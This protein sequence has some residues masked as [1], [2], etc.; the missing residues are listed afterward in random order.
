M[1]FVAI[2][3]A[4]FNTAKAEELIGDEQMASDGKVEVIYAPDLQVPYRERRS[5]WAFI[6]SISQENLRPEKFVSN[7]DG[8]SYSSLFGATNIPMIQITTGAKYNFSLGALSLELETASGQISDPRSGVSR[9]LILAKRGL[10][11]G[12]TMDAIFHEP[13]VAPYVVGQAF[14]IDYSDRGAVV[15][16]PTTV[17]GPSSGTTALTTAATVGLLIQLNSLDPTDAA[18]R[19]NYEYG[20]NNTYLDIFASQYNT[21][22][23]SRDPQFQTALNWGLGLRLEF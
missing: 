17:T 8:A 13:Y 3:L 22:N 18:T 6:I 21:S 5:P 12:W 4:L 19:A 20:L 15:P 9:S 14:V 16:D 11:A 1:F 2:F 10:R 7:Q 23:E